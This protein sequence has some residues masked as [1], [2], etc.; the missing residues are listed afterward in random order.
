MQVEIKTFRM[1]SASFPYFFYNRVNHYSSPNPDYSQ[2]QIEHENAHFR[3]LSGFS[4]I[5]YF[6]IYSIIKI[7]MYLLY[8]IY[9]H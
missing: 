2:K 3:G 5:K 1:L 9:K 7:I 6:F 8:L 4:R